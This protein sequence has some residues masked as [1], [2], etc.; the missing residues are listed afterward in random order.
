MRLESA[1]K[2]LRR[3]HADCFSCRIERHMIQAMIAGRGFVFEGDIFER[4]LPART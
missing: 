2:H 1:D 3:K 4:T